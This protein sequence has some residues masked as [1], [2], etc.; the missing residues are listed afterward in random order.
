VFSGREIHPVN[1]WADVLR[2]LK[3]WFGCRVHSLFEGNAQKNATTAAGAWWCYQIANGLH[4]K[5]NIQ[6]LCTEQRHEVGELTIW[7]VERWSLPA[8]QYCVYVLWV[9][10]CGLQRETDPSVK[11]ETV[12]SNETVSLCLDAKQRRQLAT[13]ISGEKKLA[14]FAPWE[15][16]VPHLFVILI[17]AKFPCDWCSCAVFWTPPHALARKNKIYISLQKENSSD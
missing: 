6:H 2:K 13:R 11:R 9:W 8:E 1:S 3:G 15:K 14:G 5:C 4:N 17:Q 16:K 7:K 12:A 10:E